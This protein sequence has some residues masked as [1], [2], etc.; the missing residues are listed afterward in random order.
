MTEDINDCVSLNRRYAS[1]SNVHGVSLFSLLALP[2]FPL[3]LLLL[4]SL[5]GIAYES[6]LYPLH[7]VLL[8]CVTTTNLSQ[9]VLIE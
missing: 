5:S 4:S 6:S 8:E 7:N 9:C 2:S 1:S 3:R